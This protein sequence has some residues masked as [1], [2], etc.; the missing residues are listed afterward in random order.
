MVVSILIIIAGCIPA[1]HTA[2]TTDSYLTFYDYMSAMAGM[3]LG[4]AYLESWEKKQ[5]NR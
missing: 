5:R 2:V 1:F 4:L 3:A